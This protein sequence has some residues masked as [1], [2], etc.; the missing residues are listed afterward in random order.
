M[1]YSSDLIV[2]P[3][4]KLKVTLSYQMDNED[5]YSVVKVFC[6]NE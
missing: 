4:S 1:L 5:L 3:P 6:V 2:N